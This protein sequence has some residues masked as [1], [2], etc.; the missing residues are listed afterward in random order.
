MW[1]YLSYF[2]VPFAALGL[3]LIAK[4]VSGG[5]ARHRKQS[6]KRAPGELAARAK[7]PKH[8][9]VAQRLIGGPA[10]L[11]EG[12][13]PVPRRPAPAN[14]FA[15]GAKATGTML[16]VLPRTEPAR[17]MPVD[18]SDESRSRRSRMS[19]FDS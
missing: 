4:L 8:R 18:S 6:A 7:E 2:L 3:L 17:P 16:N 10:G 14:V 15:P 1:S 13:I 9:S 5:F 11:Q 19:C 12:P